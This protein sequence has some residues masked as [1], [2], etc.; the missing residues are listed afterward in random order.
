MAKQYHVL[1][2]EDDE[3]NAELVRI[4]LKQID[5]DIAFSVVQEWEEVLNRIQHQPPDLIIS[6]YKLPDYTGMDVLMAV[7]KRFDYLPFILVSGYIGEEKAAEVMLA[8][9]TDYAMKDKLDRLKPIVRR[10]LLRYDE[11]KK[12]QRRRKRTIKQLE[13]RIKEQDCLYQISSLKELEMTTE[14]LLETAV[15]LIPN[16]W[17]YP[18]ITEAQIRLNGRTFQTEKFRKTPWML[19]TVSERLSNDD[20]EIDIAYLKEMSGKGMGPFL[21][22]ER[23]LLESIRSTLELKIN[24]IK[25]RIELDK[26]QHLLDNAYKMADIGHWEL[27]LV[28]EEL[29]W[30]DAVKQLH[31]V[32]EDYQP[33]LENA[34]AFYKEGNDRQTISYAVE[35]AINSAEPF[36]V[37]LQIITA[38][39]NERWIRAVGEAEY[40]NGQCIR[41]YGSTQN[42]TRQKQAEQELI[43][44]KQ[45]LER[46]Q[47]IGKI[48]DWDYDIETGD[49]TWSPVVYEIYEREPSLGPPSFEELLEYYHP[50]DKEEFLKTAN[51]TIENGV[52]YE[53]D[54]RLSFTDTKDKYVKH[55]GIPVRN[56]EGKLVRLIGIVQDITERKEAEVEQAR[57]EQRLKN[58]TNNINGLILQYRMN[59]EGVHDLLYVSK[60]IETLCEL[61]EEEVLKDVNLMWDLILDEDVEKVRASVL[62]NSQQLTVWNENWRIETPSGKLKWIQAYGTP[63]K[64]EEDGSVIWDT[65]LLDVTD[66]VKTEKDNKV[67]LQEVHHRVKNNLAIISGLLTLEIYGMNENG[68]KLPLQRSINRI[69]SMSKVH[70]LL[71]NTGSFSSV[72]IKD[73]LQQL[74]EVIRDTFD[75]GDGV[76]V[77]F[78]FEDL[79]VNI[80]VAIPLGMLINELMTNSFKYA[81]ENGKGRIDIGIR[82][83]NGQFHVSYHDDGRGFEKEPD[84]QNPE[85]LGMNI[86]STLLKQLGAEF[87]LQTDKRFALDFSFEGS[88]KG[89][90]GNIP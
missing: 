78:D 75:V 44:Q 34:I 45:R 31:E 72:N 17:Q 63:M 47:H 12:E 15:Q 73:Y 69:Q 49:I 71:Y 65:L 89:S 87:K 61:T 4:Q 9:A 66:Q 7:R 85:T 56:E 5:L 28:K 46:S 84:L 60:G 55:I 27:N 57:S 76:S 50:G 59:S 62:K 36:D 41:V 42:I 11:A 39:N 30:S 26:Q 90:H 24:Q 29:Y 23:Q 10:E 52:R 53:K 74:S 64:N 37:E 38:K 54:F 58:I 77:Y 2:I 3:S 32:P 70:E 21:P 16:G 1:L 82:T 67:L 86:I 20:F 6:D 88:L 22:E 81:F 43:L 19:T 35:Q 48:S 83:K 33:D 18:D 68:S 79:E 51:N 13:N 8:G 80:N 40:R 25:S 14:S